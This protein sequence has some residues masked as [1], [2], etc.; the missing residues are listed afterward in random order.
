MKKTIAL[1]ILLLIMLPYQGA[2]AASVS[3]TSVE[4]LYFE[5]YKDRVKEVREAQK[6]LYAAL[7]TELPSLTA[8][9][10]AS[11][12]QYNSLVKSKASKESIAQA[13]AVRDQDRKTL[14]SAKK[15]CTKKVNDAKKTSNNQLKEVDQYKRNM[16]AMIK[17]HLA[18]KDRMSSEEFNKK[19]QDG[20]KYINDRFDIIIR[21]LKSVR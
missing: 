18:G 8:K 10:K 1:M 12:A 7:C 15:S 13:K 9:S 4:K 5:D 16:I 19:V 14:L 17:T 2:F 11:I 6:A 20:L 3:T 21:D